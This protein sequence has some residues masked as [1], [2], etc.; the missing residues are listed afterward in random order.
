MLI[1][2]AALLAVACTKVEDPKVAESDLVG[3][4]KAPYSVGGS[5]LQGVG[6]KNL[7]INENHTATFATL[8]FNYWKIEDDELIFTYYADH[9]VDHEVDVLRYTIANFCDTVMTL[10]GTYTKTIGDS[11]YLVADMSGMYLRPKPQPDPQQ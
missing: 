3:A 6:G 8:A 5:T 4:W 9:G 10:V 11:V 2:A 7:V 1:A